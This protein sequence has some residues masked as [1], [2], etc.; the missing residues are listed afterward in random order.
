MKEHKLPHCVTT[1][2]RVGG[3]LGLKETHLDSRV[4]TLSVLVSEAELIRI[5]K[6]KG[7]V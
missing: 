7:V 3:Y 1:K 4:S 2:V 6:R 5:G